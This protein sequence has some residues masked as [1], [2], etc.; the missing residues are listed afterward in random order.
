M[1]LEVGMYVRTKKG[2]IAKIIEK[3]DNSGSLH[4]K[5]IVYKLDDNSLLALNS[6][7]VKYASHIIIDL[8]EKNDI[9]L[10][11][12]GNIY[13][14]WKIYKDYVFTYTKNKYGQTITLV[15]YQIDK[16][17]TKE[18]YESYCYKVGD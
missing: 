10:G 11:K 9:I 5:N 18:Q 6:Q 14:V 4:S 12:D 16:I 7:K 2:R 17:L 13:Q 3:F 1:K 15:D 8:I